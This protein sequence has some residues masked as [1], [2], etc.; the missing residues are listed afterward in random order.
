MGYAV[1]MG[2]TDNCPRAAKQSP[3]VLG[4]QVHLHA[5]THTKQ[6]G[7]VLQPVDLRWS[8]LLLSISANGPRTGQIYERP[9]QIS[10]PVSV[11]SHSSNGLLP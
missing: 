3:V 8:D 6:T 1:L 10:P 5:C 4:S 7:Q 11:T 9:M 2:Q